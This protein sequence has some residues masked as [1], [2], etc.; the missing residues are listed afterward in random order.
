MYLAVL[1]DPF[2]AML[3]FLVKLTH[4]IWSQK[5]GDRDILSNAL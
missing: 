4:C 3:Q 5:S 2:L 1:L